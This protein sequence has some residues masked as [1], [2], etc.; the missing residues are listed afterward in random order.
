MEC[1]K[2][3]EKTLLEFLE[4]NSIEYEYHAHPAVFTTEQADL[5]TG[6]LD[7]FHSK[8]L[9]I[10]NDKGN[11]FFLLVM[12]A[13]KKADLKALGMM[14][15]EKHIRFG[16]TEKM[17]E[18]LGVTPGSVS[19]LDLINDFDNQVNILFEKDAWAAPHIMCHPLVNTAT[20]VISHKGL[21]KFLKLINH[22]PR[23]L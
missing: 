15:Q 6:N 19:I 10:T 9:F 22:T 11:H 21:E 3:T 2:Y 8:N 23:V 1:E 12:D 4:K 18:Y 13:D 20:L 14:I 5:Y 7:A 17:G 16:S